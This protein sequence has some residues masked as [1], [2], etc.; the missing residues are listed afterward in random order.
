[1]SKRKPHNFRARIERACRALLSSNHVAVVNIDPSGKQGLVNWRNCKNVS[2]RR[3]VDAMCEIPHR[4]TIYIAGLCIGQDGE[5]YTKSLEFSPEGVH[6]AEKLTDLIQHFYKQVSDECNPNH[7]IGMA[8]LAIPSIVT[9]D[10]AQAAAVFEA[11]GAWHQEK[12][13]A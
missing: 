13:A 12:A 9:V 3:I 7:R 2:S 10:E 11:V 4:W 8:W 6:L 1:M 5:E